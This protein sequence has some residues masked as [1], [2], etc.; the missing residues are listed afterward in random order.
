MQRE[1]S[2]YLT[3]TRFKWNK[4]IVTVHTPT[5]SS[6]LYKYPF[7]WQAKE[8]TIHL[9][10]P[11]IWCFRNVL[12]SFYIANRR[13]Q[14]LLQIVLNTLCTFSCAS[15]HVLAQGVLPI[16]SHCVLYPVLCWSLSPHQYISSF[17]I[18]LK[19]YLVLTLTRGGATRNA[20]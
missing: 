20:T 1:I 7:L 16:V 8:V 6:Y 17:Y 12:I 4:V 5:V 2:F 15:T 9:L 3:S 18:N 13:K 10:F 19:P 14:T 11:T